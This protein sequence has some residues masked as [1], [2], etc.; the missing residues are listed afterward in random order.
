MNLLFGAILAFIALII[1]SP[2]LALFLGISFALLIGSN[3]EL[4]LKSTGTKLLQMGIVILGLT[5][6]SSGAITLTTKYF[7]YISLFVIVIFL[8][9]FIASKVLRIDAKLSILLVSGTAICGATAMAAISPLIK[10]KPKDLLTSLGVIFIF[11]AIA[12]A[13]L[14]IIGNH[15]EMSS[16]QFGSW[17]ALAV[18]DTSSVI[19]TALS[20]DDNAVETA[21]TLKLGR[22]LWLIPLIITLGVFYKDNKST[23]SIFPIFVFAFILAI[24]AGNQLN[25]NEQVLSILKN[26]S[27]IFLVGAL[28][29]IGTQIDLMSIK[30]IN[31]RIIIFAF[32]L[33]LFALGAAYYLVNIIL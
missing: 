15:I 18:H 6:S 3:E 2:L 26:I 5:I 17:V 31:S 4:I 28:F 21:T 9:G 30:V 8:V 25:F 22:T 33:W 10:A 19:G 24:F 14:P 1:G 11:N 16:E 7:P 29:C 13:V 32:L 20:F 27:S 23:K 12:I